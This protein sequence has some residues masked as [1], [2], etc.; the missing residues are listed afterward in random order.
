MTRPIIIAGNWKMHKT[1]AESKAL[2]EAVVSGIKGKDG[3]PTV[4]LC[5]PFT[6]L[7]TVVAAVKGS[8][9]AVG[10]QNMDPHDSGAYTGEI[11][12]TM[13]KDV[14]AGYVIIGHSERRQYFGETNATVNEKLKAALKNQLIPIVCV[15]ETLDERE[16]N[17]TDSVVSRQV[18]AGLNGI[19]AGDLKTL[20][21][22]Y[23]PVWA[24]G[25]GKVC[26]ADE[27]NRVCKLIR[28]NIGNLYKDQDFAARIPILYGGSVKPSNIDEQLAQ[29]DIDGSLVGGASLKAEEF[30]PLI[31][32]GCK[33]LTLL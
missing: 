24:I 18:A 1:R 23:E 16:S 26:E 25:T 11:S 33:A 12:P 5:P 30:L 8:P 15:G 22:A 28:T 19:E 17:L 21:I 13:L 4:V 2:A 6:S 3:L 9:I 29:S 7:E 20:V 32:S 10:G 31:E 27:A 14:G